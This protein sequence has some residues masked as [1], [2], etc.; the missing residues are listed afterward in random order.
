[1]SASTIL[2]LELNIG[3]CTLVAFACCPLLSTSPMD[4]QELAKVQAQDAYNTAA[5]TIDDLLDDLPNPTWDSTRMDTWLIDVVNHWSTCEDNWSHAGVV[6]KEWYKLEYQLLER[7][8]DLPMDL[9][10]FARM[11]FNEL[12]E[13]ALDYNLDV[14]PLPVHWVPTK[15]SKVTVSPSQSRQGAM[16]THSQT[17]TPA[18]LPA[19]PKRTPPAT[20]LTKSIPSNQLQAMP[21][22]STSNSGTSTKQATQPPGDNATVASHQ[23]TQ[24]KV[25]PMPIMAGSGNVTFPPD[26]TSPLHQKPGQNFKIGPPS[27]VARSTTSVQLLLSQLLTVDATHASS[28]P[29]PNPAEEGTDDEEEPV[30]EDSVREER[31][32]EVTGTDGE[33]DNMGGP[34]DEEDSPP[35]TKKAHR[36]HQQPRISF[37]FDKTIGDLV[38]FYP[39]I[40]LSRLIA[41]PIQSPGLWCS[42]RSDM[43]K[44]RKDPKNKDKAYVVAMPCKRT[45][46]DDDGLPTVE[47]PAAKK[48]KLKEHLEDEVAISWTIEAAACYLRHQWGGFGEKVPSTAK[49]VKNGMKSISILKVNKDFGDFMQVDESYWSK[50]VALFVGERVNGVPALNPVEHYRPQGY[51]V[52]NTFEANNTAIAAITQQFLAGLNVIAHTDNI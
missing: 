4:P 26:L 42:A 40:F 7:V 25:K 29:G 46:D 22:P 20:L 24:K 48:L 28:M 11:E 1:M 41:L 14:V 10:K 13:R 38:D 43:K 44:K 50:A 27:H 23:A 47:K 45:R 31:V 2:T 6:S 21:K 15:H 30:Q 12:V 32:E 8:P 37:V 36:L 17:V 19:T 34:D 51:D 16:A 35:P 9:V 33:G 49:A 3:D 5:S 18:P 39:T 52:V